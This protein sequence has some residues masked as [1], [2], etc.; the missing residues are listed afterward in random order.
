MCP[1]IFFVAVGATFAS[2]RSVV[3]VRRK[4]WGVMRS[5]IGVSA[6][7]IPR[8]SISLRKECSTLFLSF[9]FPL[10]VGRRYFSPMLNNIHSARIFLIGFKIGIKRPFPAAVFSPPV[11]L[12]F[13]KSTLSQGKERSSSILIPVYKRTIAICAVK[14]IPFLGSSATARILAVSSGVRILSFGP[15]AGGS[16]NPSA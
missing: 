13:S 12:P 9:L 4:A 3:A 16:S 2:T 10:S 8:S 1:I 11:R 7:F 14:C 6:W 5:L 15:G